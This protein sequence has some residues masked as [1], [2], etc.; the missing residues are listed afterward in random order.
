MSR[1]LYRRAMSLSVCGVVMLTAVASTARADLIDISGGTTTLDQL[2]GHSFIVDDKEFDI[3]GYASTGDVTIQA[4][5]IL[6]MPIDMGLAGIG[7]DL[8]PASGGSFIVD[9]YDDDDEEGN[10]DDDGLQA[11]IVLNY[12]VSILLDAVNAGFRITDA[13]LALDGV[14]TGDED[15]DSDGDDSSALAKI[16][17]TYTGAGGFSQV[18]MVQA[19]SDEV[20]VMDANF[21]DA[22]PQVSLGVEKVIDLFALGGEGYDGDEDDD[23]SLQIHYIRQT[24][25]QI[26]E[27]G[28]LGL[29]ALG[30]LALLRRRRA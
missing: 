9:M 24:F 22:T 2:I 12:T 16:T 1:Y 8:V 14:A 23:A 21:F 15:D 13:H 30:G 5:N 18:L 4:S 3:S 11:Q 27:P 6:V 19:A 26:P 25:S 28:S 20:S 7:F 17:E 29:L 10:D